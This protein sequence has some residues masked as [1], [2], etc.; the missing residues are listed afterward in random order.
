[1]NKNVTTQNGP[2][3]DDDD[4][5]EACLNAGP[6]VSAE[7][8]VRRCVRAI[9]MML[10]R[11]SRRRKTGLW[12][13]GELYDLAQRDARSATELGGRT[14]RAI[15]ATLDLTYGQVQR[16]AHL[17]RAYSLRELRLY[18]DLSTQVL[19]SARDLPRDRR[20]GVLSA[21]VAEGTAAKPGQ[22]RRFRELIEQ[23]AM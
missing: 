5:V 21:M 3:D 6:E 22:L 4:L 20:T 17:F 19:L 9:V 15:A 8:R 18:R 13:L 14:T 1:M 2:V 7:E 12:L 23:Y 16:G 10:G 11:T